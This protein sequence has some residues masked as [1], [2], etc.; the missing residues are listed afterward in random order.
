MAGLR[1]LLTP[2]LSGTEPI[3]AATSVGKGTDKSELAIKKAEGTRLVALNTRLRLDLTPPCIS[4]SYLMWAGEIA[5]RSADFSLVL[6]VDGGD[7]P[8]F[9]RA[10]DEIGIG[11]AARWL[12]DGIDYWNIQLRDKAMT[13]IAWNRCAPYY[14]SDREP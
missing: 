2:D 9:R 8:C 14:E 3:Q 11:I 10:S 1:S 6:W 13:D 7:N 5:A 12:L 4:Y